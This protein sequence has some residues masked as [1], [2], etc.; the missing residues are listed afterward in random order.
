MARQKTFEDAA[1]ASAARDVFWRHGYVATSLAQLQ[2][3]TGL[4]K[5][6]LY[7]SYG[8]KRGL[9][10]RAIR[11][12]LDTV[13]D[14]LLAPLEAEGAGR[15]ELTAYFAALARLFREAP[16][17]IARRGC[18][19]LNTAMELDDLDADAARAVADYR[20]RIRTAFANAHAADPD[21]LTAAQIGLMVTSRLDPAQAADLADALARF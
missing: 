11:D 13:I 21:L 8:S 18:L 20:E 12:Y 16:H 4:S 3:A 17:P 6:S 10:D 7:E 15:A 2:A 14:P 9:F 1:V 19:L 5:S